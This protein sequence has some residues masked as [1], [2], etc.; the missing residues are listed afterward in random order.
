MKIG[1]WL[2]NSHSKTK[3][4]KNTIPIQASF[5]APR[6]K[7]ANQAGYEAIKRE[8]LP[9]AQRDFDSSEGIQN[10]I[11]PEVR[12]QHRV[13]LFF[14]SIIFHSPISPFIY[15]FFHSLEPSRTRDVIIGKLFRDI[16]FPPTH[17]LKQRL[18]FHPEGF[19]PSLPS[20]E[21]L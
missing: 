11:L 10:M 2:F 19:N 15:I 3:T 21:S 20:L 9:Q 18:Q 5:V 7:A 12:L 14:F 17:V 4:K 8:L 1:I 6:I 13:F 16:W